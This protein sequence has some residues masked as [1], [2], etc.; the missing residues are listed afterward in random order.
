MPPVFR[1][2]LCPPLA[3]DA[4]PLQAWV[5]RPPGARSNH[6]G[7]GS[8]GQRRSRLPRGFP[9]A[10]QAFLQATILPRAR[11]L[12]RHSLGFGVEVKL[13][14]SSP[15]LPSVFL[16]SPALPAERGAGP[17]RWKRYRPA[18]SRPSSASGLAGPPYL[19]RRRVGVPELRV[20][21]GERGPGPA[22]GPAG[23]C[24]RGPAGRSHCSG[25]ASS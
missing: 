9:K 10:L 7:P 15:L 20:G 18:G 21:H 2:Y 12:L 16:G 1:V 23:S 6:V 24:A 17:A 11:G 19:G 4:F 25:A 22:G 8:P 13:S 5:P 3:A 14:A